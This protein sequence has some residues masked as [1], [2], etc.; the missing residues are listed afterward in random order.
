MAQITKIEIGIFDTLEVGY[1]C[2]AYYHIRKLQLE[3][4]NNTL[5]TQQKK[6]KL[7]LE[8]IKSG[9]QSHQSLFYNDKLMND[10]MLQTV[11]NELYLKKDS[12]LTIQEINAIYADAAYNISHT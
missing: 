8:V 9:K 11:T 12:Y 4:S 7:A 1:L 2:S 5:V 10:L 3:V 6:N